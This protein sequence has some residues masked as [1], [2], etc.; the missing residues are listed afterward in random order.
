VLLQACR[1]RLLLRLLLLVVAP[2]G[3]CLRVK[4]HQGI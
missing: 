1:C 4:T 2:R 3:W